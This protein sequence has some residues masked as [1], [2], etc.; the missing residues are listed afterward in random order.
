MRS[1]ARRLDSFLFPA[2]TD[3]WIAILR[4]GMGCLVILYCLSLRGDW[5]EFFLLGSAGPIK[6]DLMEAILSSQS[7]L[8]P[9]LGWLVDAGTN[10]GLSERLVISNVWW[11][12]LLAGVFLVAGL[13]A[14]ANAVMAA[15]LHLC[16]VKSTGP[17]TYGFDNF[18]TIGLFYL[19]LSPLP[20]HFSLDY[21][22]L[23]ITGNVHLSGFFR[24]VLQL[25][26][27]LIYFF[28]GITKI[29]GP[30]WW[31]G[32]SI[33][34]AMIRPPFNIVPPD[35]LIF[36]KILFPSIAI[37][38]WVIEL[39]YPLFIWLRKTRLIWFSAVLLMHIGIG[40]TLGLRLFAFVM[41]VLNVAAFGP[42]Y[43]FADFNLGTVFRDKL[44]VR[45]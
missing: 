26:L 43:A 11:L 39:G 13:F 41:I 18:S 7:H 17:L 42:G 37:S 6:R 16:A 20:D 30:G 27:C 25:H 35:V 10:L 23:R 44:M 40:A 22:R 36:W 45:L 15:F 33:W 28:G 2:E 14:R 32:S 9:R 21:L 3:T 5:N 19:V 38:V 1:A 29:A 4:I 34:R 12:L 8:I 31:D 24:R